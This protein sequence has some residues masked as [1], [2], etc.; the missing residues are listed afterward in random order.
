MTDPA[1]KE[2]VREQVLS[3]MTKNE[4]SLWTVVT[5]EASTEPQ[6]PWGKALSSD[7]Q[8]QSSSSSSFI[9]KLLTICQVLFMYLLI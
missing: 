9:Y 1:F 6:K 4:S 5:L 3:P 7:Y 8:Q 2:L